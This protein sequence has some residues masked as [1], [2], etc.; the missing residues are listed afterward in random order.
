LF[1]TVTLPIFEPVTTNDVKSL[2][3][4]TERAAAFKS[5]LR[6]IDSTF[7]TDVKLTAPRTPVR[8]AVTKSL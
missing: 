7:G 2:F 3:P 5:A 4:V 6:V 1:W 8:L